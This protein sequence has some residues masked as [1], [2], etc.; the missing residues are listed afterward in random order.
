MRH[1]E[2][3]K[4]QLS[5]AKTKYNAKLGIE[6]DNKL[7]KVLN[8]VIDCLQ[9]PEIIAYPDF[10]SPFFITC[11]P[12]YDRLGTVLYQMGVN[13]VICFA[14]RTLPDTEKII[15]YIL[16][17]WSFGIEVG[18]HGEVFGLFKIWTACR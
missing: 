9:S 2:N 12:C 8:D 14:S 16:E 6:W 13:R 1:S 17:N 11:D 7:Q 10:E 18:S 15:I 3:N 4:I 5:N